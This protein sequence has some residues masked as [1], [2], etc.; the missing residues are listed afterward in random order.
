MCAFACKTSRHETVALTRIRQQNLMRRE[1]VR[2]G[3]ECFKFQTR[4]RACSPA[5]SP[6]RLSPRPAIGC[7]TTDAVPSHSS[8]APAASGEI[9][10]SRAKAASEACWQCPPKG[11]QRSRWPQTRKRGFSHN[12]AI[13]Q[14][15]MQREPHALAVDGTTSKQGLAAYVLPGR[16]LRV[17]RVPSARATI[18]ARRQGVH[19]SLERDGVGGKLQR[20]D[21]SQQP[22]GPQRHGGGCVQ[23]L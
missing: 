17:H 22:K 13:N 2:A 3:V 8:F 5:N 20:C 9:M 19:E 10:K 1:T 15:G 7:H 18:A 23:P 11:R 6:M 4:P 21:D 12:A 14:Y 16:E